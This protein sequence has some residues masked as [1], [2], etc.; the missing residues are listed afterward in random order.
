MEYLTYRPRT[1][2]EE[3]LLLLFILECL[4]HSFKTII[5][6]IND[7]ALEEFEGFLPQV[8]YDISY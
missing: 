6:V 7:F 5:E 2:S 1:W 8:F 3:Y 4:K